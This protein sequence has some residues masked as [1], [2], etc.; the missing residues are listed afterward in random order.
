MIITWKMVYWFLVG[1][2]LGSIIAL[3]KHRLNAWQ[4]LIINTITVV[5]INFIIL[6]TKISRW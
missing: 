4:W 1:I 3:F 6:I 5:L 2:W